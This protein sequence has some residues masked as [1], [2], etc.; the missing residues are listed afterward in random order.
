[1][2]CH[3]SLAIIYLLIGGAIASHSDRLTGFLTLFGTPTLIHSILAYGSYRK[4]ELSRKLSV[5]MFVLLAIGTPPVG[6]IVAIFWLLPTTIWAV[7]E[8]S[9]S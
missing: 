3:I 4:V 2:K 1:M 5:F 6:T 7:P 9:Q 8:N